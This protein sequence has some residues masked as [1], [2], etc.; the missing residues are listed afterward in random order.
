MIILVFDC[1]SK[2]MAAAVA[3]DGEILAEDYSAE[4]RNHA[5]FLMPMIDGVLKKAELQYK[6]LDAIGVT[7][8][9]GSFTGLRIGIATAK[10]FADT[11][12]IPILP[13]MSLDALA[14]G[15][16]DY[17]GIIVT[18]LDARKN[19]VYAAVYQNSQGEM[20]KIMK[21]TPLSP[22][23]E[24]VPFL[25]KYD[26]ILFVGDGVPGWQ[27]RLEETYGKV[28]DSMPQRPS[29]IKG[30]SLC[31]L[32]NKAKSWDF[33]RDVEPFYIRGVDAKAKFL[34]CN[35]FPLNEGDIHDLLE[36]EQG[37]FPRPWTEKMFL[38]ELKNEFAH[39][40]I[41]RTE[42]KLSAYGGFWR[43]GNECHI[44]NIAVH[45]DY[46]HLGQGTLMVEYILTKIKETGSVAATLEVRIS[47]EKAIAIYE[48]AG[49]ERSGIRPKYYEDDGEDA[50]IM[51]KTFNNRDDKEK[52]W[53][54]KL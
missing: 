45:P 2:T 20:R 43:I 10:G 46:R 27:H 3:Q 18:I 31:I 14:E 38:D 53:S 42:G 22:V 4:N 19:Q 8:G 13:M 50:L 34:N 7:I 37:S 17:H 28:F 54:I 30:E 35:F 15:Y 40:W 36:V 12:N 41:I 6:D 9:P 23:L 25:A 33:V 24:L 32:A 39:Y 49:F 52:P 26:K 51:W 21:E 16:K 47:N 48:K 29:G 11:L 5:P 1:S 44:T